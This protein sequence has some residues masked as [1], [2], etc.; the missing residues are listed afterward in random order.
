MEN[1]RENRPESLP[2]ATRFP[3]ILAILFAL[4]ATLARAEPP[5]AFEWLKELVGEWEGVHR[6]NDHVS[7]ETAILRPNGEFE[8]IFRIRGL[9]GK[10]RSVKIH[11][12]LWG[13]TGNIHYTITLKLQLDDRVVNADM[14]KE[15]VYNAYRVLKLTDTEFQY[16]DIRN[17]MQYRLQRK[18]RREAD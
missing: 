4:P 11:R 10:T 9:D 3:A 8:F 5:A 6:Y 2:T 1:R 12:G 18:L 13:L 16:S 15:T 14:T 17:G 7:E